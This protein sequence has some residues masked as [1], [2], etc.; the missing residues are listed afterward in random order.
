MCVDLMKYWRNPLE[1]GN[2]S[3]KKI[4]N[5]VPCLS[6]SVWPQYLLHS[7]FD[8]TLHGKICTTFCVKLDY[9]T[10]FNLPISMPALSKAWLCGCSLVGIAFSNPAVGM[11]ACLICVVRYLVDVSASGLTLA[12]R[13]PTECSV[14][15]CDGKTS[16][17]RRLLPIRS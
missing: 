10:A 13:I 2:T 5:F 4:E 15:E 7:D 11:D 1:D 12:H 3:R 9:I 8:R 17:M 16:I 6:F 14:S